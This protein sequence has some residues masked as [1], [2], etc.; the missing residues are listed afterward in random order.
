MI[1]AVFGGGT[2]FYQYFDK[3]DVIVKAEEDK[4]KAVHE[5]AVGFQSAMVEKTT[6]PKIV[7]RTPSCGDCLKRIEKL[8]RWH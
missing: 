5:V 4:N 6:T 3:Q 7:V 8:E 1:I 2:G